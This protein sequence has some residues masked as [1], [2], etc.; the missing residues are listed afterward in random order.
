LSSC[1]GENV[2]GVE[3]GC[4]HKLPPALA[5]LFTE[6]PNAAIVPPQSEVSLPPLWQPQ[7]ILHQLMFTSVAPSLH[8]AGGF[9]DQTGQGWSSGST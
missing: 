8:L 6:E 5:V 4:P 2:L 7:W 3:Q 1:L 9:W